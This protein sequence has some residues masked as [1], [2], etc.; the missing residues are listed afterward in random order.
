MAQIRELMGDAPVYISF[1]IDIVDPGY[2]PG[3][4]QY[5]IVIGFALLRCMIGLFNNKARILNN[6]ALSVFLSS[7]QI[8]L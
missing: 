6:C 4:G 7:R 1:D 3:T 2:A 5:R 8:D